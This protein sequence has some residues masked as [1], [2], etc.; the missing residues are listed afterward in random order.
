MKVRLCF[1]LVLIIIQFN[2]CFGF[3]DGLTLYDPK[4]KSTVTMKHKMTNDGCCDTYKCSNCIKLHPTEEDKT[5]TVWFTTFLNRTDCM[6]FEEKEPS[7]TTHLE[8]IFEVVLWV[9][10]V[11]FYI[12]VIFDNILYP[13]W[14]FGFTAIFPK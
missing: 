4:T 2:N 6:C 11:I 8:K 10:H 5:N 13:I 1:S 3:G 14:I 12:R 9:V 7:L